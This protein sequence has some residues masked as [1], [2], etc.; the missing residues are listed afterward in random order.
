MGRY[1]I[2]L[3]YD[4]TNYF[5]WQRQPHSISVEEVI[6]DVIRTLCRDGNIGI[7]GCGRTDTGVSAK[8]YYAHFDASITI[9]CKE[10]KRKMNMMLPKDI[11][12]EDI[13]PCGLHAR[14]D[15]TRREYKYYISRKK[16]P[17]DKHLWIVHQ[18]L[19]IE[20]MR[21]GCRVLLDYSDFTSFAKLH[22]NAETNIC[23]IYEAK[24]EETEDGL[25]FTIA[26]NRFLRGM[27][28][29]ITGTLVDLGRGKI[30]LDYL[31]TIIEGKD[32]SLASMQAPSEGLFL[33]K[34]NYPGF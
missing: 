14:F 11:S 9:D 7:V 18:P 1:F 32:R 28:R 17:F 25:I 3:S 19:D 31:R 5:G 27:V 12:I 34:I 2:K 13:F 26:A 16:N 29:A 24:I 22:G 10:F 30:T 20:I 6:T 15:A 23:K 4:G 8:D 21:D 33:T